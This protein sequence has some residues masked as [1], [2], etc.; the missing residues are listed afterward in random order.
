MTCVETLK[1]SRFWIVLCLDSWT[2][3]LFP[4][5]TSSKYQKLKRFFYNHFQFSWIYFVDCSPTRHPTD[6]ARALWLGRLRDSRLAVILLWYASVQYTVRGGAAL[7]QL[8]ADRAGKQN[9]GDG[10]NSSA[11]LAWG[12][13]AIEF[14][15]ILEPIKRHKR[16]NVFQ[17]S[18]LFCLAWIFFT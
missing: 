8:L 6:D 9:F 2:I 17:K 5:A 14:P 16:R 12:E 7:H 15:K 11:C 18:D 3:F 10:L 4:N 13:E 1:M